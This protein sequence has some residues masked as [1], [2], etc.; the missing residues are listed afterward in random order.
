MTESNKTEETIRI[1]DLEDIENLIKVEEETIQDRKEIPEEEKKY[2]KEIGRNFLDY[3]VF[4]PSEEDL[5]KLWKNEG[6][7][8]NHFINHIFY[9]FKPKPIVSF[10]LTEFNYKRPKSWGIRKHICIAPLNQQDRIDQIILT[11]ENISKF[12]K[13][14]AGS[15]YVQFT[16]DKELIDIYYDNNIMYALKGT[17]KKKI[18]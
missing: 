7:S 13:V 6:P 5:D 4:D 14:T 3:L 11:P 17:E 16:R 10:Y 15:L 18:S 8:D 9:K 2:L 1:V 12:R